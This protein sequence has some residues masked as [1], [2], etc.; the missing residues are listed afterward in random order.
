MKRFYQINNITDQ[1]K[2]L[3]LCIIFKRMCNNIYKSLKGFKKGSAKE[4]CHKGEDLNF[5]IL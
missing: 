1:L 3:Y 5:Q 4:Q 2:N